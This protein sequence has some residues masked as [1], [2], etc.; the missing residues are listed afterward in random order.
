MGRD[1]KMWM[2]CRFTIKDKT[3]IRMEVVCLQALNE[4]ARIH[5]QNREINYQ[6]LWPKTTLRKDLK[7]GL[8]IRAV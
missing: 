4:E 1:V 8:R 6:K 2:I 5:A 7:Y 3:Q